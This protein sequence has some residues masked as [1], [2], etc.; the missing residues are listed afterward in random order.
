[1][2]EH[3]NSEGILD[4][5]TAPQLSIADLSCLSIDWFLLALFGFYFGSPYV[6]ILKKLYGHIVHRRKIF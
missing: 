1:M 5:Q 2:S 3:L 6:I 4:R